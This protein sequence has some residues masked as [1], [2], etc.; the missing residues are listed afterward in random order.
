MQKT[1]I[2]IVCA[3]LFVGCAP[4]VNVARFDNIERSPTSKLD[5]YTSFESIDREYKEIALITAQDRIPEKT[6][7][8]MVEDLKRKAMEIGADAIVL[9]AGEIESS[10]DSYSFGVMTTHTHTAKATAIIYIN[11]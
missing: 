7:I 3:L 11:K 9:Q 2:L 10:T 8:E 4:L 6:E 1:I 5:I